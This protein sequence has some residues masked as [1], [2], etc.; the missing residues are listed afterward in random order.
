MNPK[1]LYETTMDPQKRKLLKVEIADAIEA[2][3]IFITLMG[4]DV[5]PRKRFIEENALQ[6]KNLDI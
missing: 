5:E 3:K 1:Q 4:E 2:E 6:V